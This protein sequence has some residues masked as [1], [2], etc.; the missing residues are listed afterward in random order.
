MKPFSAEPLDD[1]AF[2]SFEVFNAILIL[3]Q[4]HG[5]GDQLLRFFWGKAFQGKI[6]LRF[7]SIMFMQ[8]QD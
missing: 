5:I 4:N 3:F 1:L 6:A 7:M 2:L 8:S